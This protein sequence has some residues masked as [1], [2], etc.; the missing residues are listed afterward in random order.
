MV[1]GSSDTCPVF[2][3]EMSL[4]VCSS[5]GSGFRVFRVFFQFGFGFGFGFLYFFQF[6]FG[7][8]FLKVCSGS[9]SGSGFFQNPATTLVFA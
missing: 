3:L 8:G 5:P 1:F 4:R 9:G 6:G 2:R 7:F